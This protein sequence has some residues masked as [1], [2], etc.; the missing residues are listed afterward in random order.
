M[1]EQSVVVRPREVMPEGARTLP[2]RYYTDH[3]LFNA[4]LDGLFG[5]MW[6]YAGRS[7]EIERAGQTSS[8]S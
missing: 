8:A 1:D 4:E 2:A 5:R 3:G 7:E 6:F